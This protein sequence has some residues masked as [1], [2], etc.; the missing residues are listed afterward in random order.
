MTALTT[1]VDR[2]ICLLGTQ[3]LP[4]IQL[5]YEEKMGTDIQNCLLDKKTK[6]CVGTRH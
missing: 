6:K 5:I 2:F 4:F 3:F 1:I